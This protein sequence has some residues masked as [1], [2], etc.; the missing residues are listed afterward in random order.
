MERYNQTRSE[1][2]DEILEILFIKREGGKSISSEALLKI[3]HFEHRFT[4]EVI[5]QSIEAGLV[6]KKNGV[7]ELTEAGVR[8]ATQIIRCYRLAERLLT[9]I[10]NVQDDIV[11]SSAC[12]FEHILSEEVAESICTLLGHPRTCPHGRKIPPGECCKRARTKVAPIIR[13]LSQLMAGETGTIA[14]IS[15]PFHDRLTKL[16]S[17]G[18]SPGQEI[19]VRQVRPSFII[20]Y[21]E[22]E[23]A[24][25]KS[26]A[27]EIY[28][29]ISA[30]QN[31]I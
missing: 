22:T 15:S 21:G 27:D 17:M 9:D 5:E 20:S 28:L 19:I 14:Y 24:I 16:G 8:R 29:R 10:L 25:E 6:N 4:K 2:F 12:R 30:N 26:V 31:K 3:E 18:L 11:E 23:L 13:P 7:L 1:L